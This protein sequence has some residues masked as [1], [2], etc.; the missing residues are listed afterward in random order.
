MT[1]STKRIS[2]YWHSLLGSHAETLILQ[3]HLDARRGLHMSL[4]EQALATTWNTIS[5][6]ECACGCHTLLS[7]KTVDRGWT[8]IRGHK[9]AMSGVVHTQTKVLQNKQ[10]APLMKAAVSTNWNSIEQFVNDSLMLIQGQITD[11]KQQLL[12]LEAKIAELRSEENKLI[13][14]KESLKGL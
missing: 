13:K 2:K 1:L 9:A 4:A 8:V 5:K 7:Q 6:I 10:R 11:V 12:K 3:A 14:V